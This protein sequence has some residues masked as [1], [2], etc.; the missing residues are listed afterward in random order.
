MIHQEVLTN[1]SSIYS[2]DSRELRFSRALVF[3]VEEINN[4]SYL[5][6][7]VTLGY[8]VHDQVD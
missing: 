1:P 3:A 6:P 8:Q 2:M 4:S 7:G 5:L